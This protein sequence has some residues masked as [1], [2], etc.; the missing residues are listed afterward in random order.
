MSVSKEKL[1]ERLEDCI[2]LAEKKGDERGAAV[3]QNLLDDVK[4]GDLDE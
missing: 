1:T 3:L 4:T 2:E